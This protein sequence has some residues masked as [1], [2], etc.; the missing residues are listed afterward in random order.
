MP[1]REDFDNILVFPLRKANWA[2][3][4]ILFVAI[5]KEVFVISV[6]VGEQFL[7]RA[8]GSPAPL[9]LRG[10]Y[11]LS[12]EPA[13]KKGEDE[14]NPKDATTP[15]CIPPELLVE[16]VRLR[17]I[18]ALRRNQKLGRKEHRAQT[19]DI[20]RPMQN[21]VE[22]IQAPYALMAH[23]DLSYSRSHSR[24]EHADAHQGEA[25]E[26]RK[27]NQRVLP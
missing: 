8:L 20:E 18:V 27:K 14:A 7:E 16:T 13:M 9:F 10:S 2:F 1:A 6:D 4:G 15:V 24:K 26:V 19:K 17:L 22:S 21:H 11:R 25:Q 23:L 5:T 12:K 3:P